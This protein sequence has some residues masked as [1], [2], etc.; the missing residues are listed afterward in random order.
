MAD[1][2]VI[3]SIR[4]DSS[5]LDSDFAQ[6]EK[7]AKSG[8]EKLQNGLKTT[9]KVAAATFAAIG[10]AA[11]A[12]GTKSVNVAND[13]DKAMNQFFAST[14]VSAQET[15][16]DVTGAVIGT[17]DKTK[18]YED[19][20]KSIYTAGFG[21]SFEDIG[22]AMATVQQQVDGIDAGGLESLTQSGLMLRDI[23]GFDVSESV[24]AADM[25]MQQ[26]GVDGETAMGLIATGA[27]NGLDYSGELL[28]SISE[29]SV[30][31]KNLGLDADDMFAI[32]EAGAES[33]AFSLDKIGDAAKEFSIRVMDGSQ[34]TREGFQAIG[35]D[36]D[37][38]IAKFAAGGESAA[39]AWNQTISALSNTDDALA[40]NSAGVALFGTMWEDLG[41][42]AVTQLSAINAGAY[43]TEEALATMASVKYDDLSSALEGM[44]RAVDTLLAPLGEELVPIMSD[45]I[46]TIMPVLE[47][48]MPML[49]DLIG[50]IAE[51]IMPIIETV[52][53]IIMD[54]FSSL[55]PLFVQLVEDVLPPIL[56]LIMQLLPPIMQLIEEL[57]PPIMEIL[58]AL[59][60]PL[61]SLLTTILTP[62][63]DV[64]MTLLEP[65]MELVNALLP[66][67]VDLINTLTPLFEALS[68]IIKMLGDVLANSIGFALELITPLLQGLMDILGAVIDFIT[69]VFTGNWEKAW[70]GIVGI[71]KGIF[72]II[73]TIVESV[74]NGAIGIINGIIKGINAATGLIG[75]KEIPLIPKVRL[76]RFQA[77]ID[78]VAED[79]TPAFLDRGE[80]VLTREENL[81][82]TA[83]G[84][85]DGLEKMLTKQ[86][87]LA[88]GT[89]SVRIEVPLNLDGREVARATAWYMGEQLSWEQL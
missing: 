67:L 81:R 27:Q 1:G 32:M 35:L 84:G 30:H 31:F 39:E 66:P 60:P 89:K 4:G 19:V 80:R 6:A 16:T 29:Y 64:L 49:T 86:L 24:R 43:S 44:T 77:G 78:Y 18:E 57:L 17:V 37:E 87:S 25:L 34:T 88:D 48:N 9:G 5:Q 73:P 79:F 21:E 20:L 42:E 53:P 52:L 55:M 14:G 7:T 13:M 65:I 82:Y 50:Q 72:N 75:I 46:D 56:D 22:Q 33:G 10:S 15:L 70:D 59:L 12:A 40:Q 47:E 76:P 8:G 54:L 85:V 58:N 36:A 28:D 71:F 41:A 68:P 45:I 74:I 38:M 11:V 63:I 26:F 61:T 62:L 3:F 2:S 83:L 69:G 23:Y 51:A